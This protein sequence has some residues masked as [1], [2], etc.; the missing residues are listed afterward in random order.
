MNRI[1]GSFDIPMVENLILSQIFA[2]Y[3][4]SI[5]IVGLHPHPT[6]SLKRRGNINFSI[7][8]S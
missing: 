3:L 2:Y 7:L 1:S 4:E 6:L 8:E 5:F